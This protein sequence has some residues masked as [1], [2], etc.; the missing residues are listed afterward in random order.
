MSI[1]FA[2]AGTGASPAVARVLRCPA[3]GVPTNDADDALLGDHLLLAALRH[4]ARHGA[5]TTQHA[6]QIALRAHRASDMARY[7]HWLSICQTLVPRLTKN[8]PFPTL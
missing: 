3:P 4:Y 6:C 5:T 2:A 1:R 7:H 8:L